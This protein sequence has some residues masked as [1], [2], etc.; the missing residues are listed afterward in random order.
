MEHQKLS[1]ATGAKISDQCV[2]PQHH[3][4]H[5]E[6][7]Q[8]GCADVERELARRVCRKPVCDVIKPGGTEPLARPW[9]HQAGEVGAED[10]QLRVR[11][12]RA[13]DAVRSE[14]LDGKGV[15]RQHKERDHGGSGPPEDVRATLQDGGAVD[16][17]QDQQG[18]AQQE[19]RDSQELLGDQELGDE[20]RPQDGA[21]QLG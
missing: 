3:H 16:D 6:Q 13:G 15:S 18:D 9:S 4:G 11:L 5:T 7:D 20:E 8:Q 1:S 12:G 10:C 17:G 19:D 14:E 21:A 2:S